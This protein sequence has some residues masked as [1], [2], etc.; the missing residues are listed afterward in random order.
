MLNAICQE[1]CEGV[2]HLNGRTHVVMEI[3]YFTVLQQRLMPHGYV[4]ESVLR[5]YERKGF[6]NATFTK[7]KSDDLSHP[8]SV[9]G[10]SR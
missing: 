2:Y 7:A 9:F 6:C 10:S 8:E 1:F 5:T 4:Y 3:Q